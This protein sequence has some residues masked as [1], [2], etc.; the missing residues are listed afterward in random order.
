MRRLIRRITRLLARCITVAILLP[1]LGDGV[2]AQDATTARR[3]GVS[4][5]LGLAWSELS[6][7]A[8]KGGVFGA[9]RFDLGYE[10]PFGSR[11]GLRIEGS[12]SDVRT[13][14]G[15]TGDIFL[16]PTTVSAVRLGLGVQA[17][18]Y[19]DRKAFVGA[20]FT[21][22]ADAGC[23][24]DTEGGPG[25]LEGS[26]VDC[27]EFTAV[28]LRPRSGVVG[29]VLTAGV[30]R[31]RWEYELRYD[32]AVTPTIDADAGPL[33]GRSVAGVVHYRF[34]ARR[35]ADGPGRPNDMRPLQA[36][37]SFMHQTGVSS[38]GF[39][40]GVAAGAGLGALAANLSGDGDNLDEVGTGTLV[41]AVLGPVAALHWDGRRH[42]RRA[43]LIATITGS[44]LG[45][46]VGAVAAYGAG[47]AA[48]PI[49]LIGGPVGAT[50]GYRL[51]DRVR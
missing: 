10:R 1:A 17:R 46:A 24:V 26:T 3:E 7:T 38:A 50:A 39:L 48:M 6:G 12:V 13:D 11:I 31:G 2:R 29:A 25:F 51:T 8:S 9:G 34:G 32:H 5:S 22:S 18:R 4:L 19:S 45:T 30:Q 28:S 15:E 41:G 44:L 23:V 49:V 27:D 47:E 36:A 37:P 16:L 42:G 33:R 40:L 14:L 21:V 20:G 43:S 35:G